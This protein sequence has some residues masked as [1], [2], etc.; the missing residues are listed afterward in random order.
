MHEPR[1]NQ[2]QT[3]SGEVTRLLGAVADGQAVSDQ[4]F[5]LVYDELRRLA[6][7]RLARD[8][9]GQTLQPTALVH[10][11]YLRLVGGDGAEVRWQNHA[12]F[13]GAAALAMKRILI[14]R[15]RRRALAREARASQA[16]AELDGEGDPETVDLIALDDALT[17]LGA[18]DAR[19]AEL[20]HLRF[21]AGLTVEQA[22]EVMGASA[23]TVKRDWSFARAW[24][25]REMTGGAAT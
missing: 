16:A 15:A 4:L 13:F 24:L 21:F 6:A 19:L 10:E 17:R 25:H 22:A 20:V 1:P 11:A 7:A 9:A 14:E 8:A 12:H 5:P 2:G 18:V 3:G 23:R